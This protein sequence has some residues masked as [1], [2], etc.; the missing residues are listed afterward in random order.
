MAYSFASDNAAVV[1][2]KIMAALAAC[3]EGT[4]PPYGADAFSTRLNRVYS[5][6]F[7][8]E[9]FVFPV[10]S[11]T[12]ANGLALGSATPSY[13]VVFCHELAHIVVSEAGSVEFYSGGGRLVHLSGEHCKI[14]PA[15][16]IAALS[17]YGPTF[18]HQMQASTLSLTQATERGTIYAIDEIKALSEVARR[19]GLRVHMDGARFANALVTLGVSPAAM[20]WKAGVDI[21]S[22][23]TTKNGAMMSE[24]VI[25]FDKALAEIVRLKHKRAGFLH[26]KMRYFS[27]QLITYVEGGLWLENARKA[28]GTARRI[29]SAFAATPS[30]ELAHPVEGNQIFAHIPPGAT[31]ALQAAGIALRPWASAK[32]NQYRIVTS[33][34]DP[35]NLVA[36]LEFC[37]EGGTH[38]MTMPVPSIRLFEPPGGLE[39]AYGETARIGLISLSTDIAIER[40]FTRMV[41]DDSLGLYTTR[42]RL[43]W[44]NTDATF[45]ALADRIPDAASVIVPNVRLDAIVFGCTTASTLIG[46]ERVEALVRSRRP[47]VKVTNPALAAV[48]ALKA[49]DARRIVLITPYTVQMT[50]NVVRFFERH[51]ISLVSAT[52]TGFDTD[53]S[54]GRVPAAAFLDAALSAERTGADAIFVSCTA[55][56]ALNVIDELERRTGLPVVTSNQAAF[57]HAAKLAGWSRPIPGFGTLMTRHFD[58]PTSKAAE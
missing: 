38:A 3:N 8:H 31:A 11:G 46:P 33:Y 1:H 6:L 15:A 45:L 24:A 37:I 28:N 52:C 41:P 47:D 27:A 48:E 50:G 5:D 49:L 14:A 53:E 36:R 22:F 7:E 55:T 35:E 17:G 32:G 56:K 9:A 29:A 21:V 20:T 34:C 58:P 30:V 54:I 42:I 4:A 18:L 10:S 16:L 44:P 43:D 57:W 26:S 19:T 40:D 13:G 25:V 39:A 12:A 51:G 23:G 2:P